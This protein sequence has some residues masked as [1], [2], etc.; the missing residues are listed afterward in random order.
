MNQPPDN[1]IGLHAPR[2]ARAPWWSRL[3]IAAVV[4]ALSML[5]GFHLPVPSGTG[6]AVVAAQTTP[7]LI[8]GESRDHAGGAREDRH[9]DVPAKKARLIA[10]KVKTTR[11]PG[12]IRDAAS[13]LP[14]SRRGHAGPQPDPRMPD[15]ALHRLDPS[16]S[17]HHGQAPPV[18]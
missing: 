12:H 3:G 9:R 11:A 1:P 16:L 6:R 14:S 17:L 5:L 13:P 7:A 4:I 8:A 15:G 18:A 2:P 10:L